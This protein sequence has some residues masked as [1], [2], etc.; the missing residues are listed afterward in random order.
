[1]WGHNADRGETGFDCS[2]FVSYVYHHALG[3]QMNGNSNA[4]EDT[5]GVTVPEWDMRKGDLLIFDNGRHVGIYLGNDQMIQCG[6]GLGKVGVLPL[7]PDTEWGKHL[8]AVR[9][10][11]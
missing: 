7:G 9:R 4:I 1:M 11:F 6:G 5:V 2:N 10:M 3:Y 8:S